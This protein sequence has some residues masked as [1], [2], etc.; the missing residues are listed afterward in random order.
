MYDNRENPKKVGKVSP[1]HI[2]DEL[3]FAIF[4]TLKAEVGIADVDE[5]GNWFIWKSSEIEGNKMIEKY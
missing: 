5:I 4:S 1:R 3:G 2:R